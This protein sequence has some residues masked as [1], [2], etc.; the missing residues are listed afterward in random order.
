VSQGPLSIASSAVMRVPLMQG[1]PT[2]TAGST[3]MRHGF[4]GKQISMIASL[5]HRRMMVN[6]W[7]QLHYILRETRSCASA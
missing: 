6:V 3:D 7:H 4:H 5:A 2:I 1:L